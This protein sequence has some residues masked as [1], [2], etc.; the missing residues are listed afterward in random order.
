MI[1]KAEAIDIINKFDFFQGQRAG[2]ELWSRKHQILQDE[3]IRNFNRDCA[4]LLEY[5]SGTETAASGMPEKF[6]LIFNMP[7]FYD[8][9]E[10]TTTFITYSRTGLESISGTT[11]KQE[12]IVPGKELGITLFFSKEAA[13]LGLEKLIEDYKALN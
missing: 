1:T 5:I 10:Y 3:D 11:G 4:L 2:R 8:I 7:G 12:A 13:K 9:V 6:W